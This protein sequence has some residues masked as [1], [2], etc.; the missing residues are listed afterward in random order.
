ME[1]IIKTSALI[2][3]V[4]S[5]FLGIINRKQISSYFTQINCGSPMKLKWLPG[6]VVWLLLGLSLELYVFPYAKTKR[7]ALRSAFIF[8]IITY[9]IYDLTNLATITKWTLGFTLTDILWGGVLMV[10]V[11]QI[12]F[13]LQKL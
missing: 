10:I 2:A 5:I 8:G 7:D 3:V 11:T 1:Q 4:D 13:Q 12:K 9:A 6:I